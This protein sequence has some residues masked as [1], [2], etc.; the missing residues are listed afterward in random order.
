ML[1]FLPNWFVAWILRNLSDDRIHNAWREK[2]SSYKPHFNNN[3]DLKTDINTPVVRAFWAEKDNGNVEFMVKRILDDEENRIITTEVMKQ[4]AEA[5]K[6]KRST[7]QIEHTN[8][9]QTSQIQLPETNQE[10]SDGDRDC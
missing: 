2:I 6:I 4:M 3:S 1:S 9:S 8:S 7:P 5:Y 10:Y